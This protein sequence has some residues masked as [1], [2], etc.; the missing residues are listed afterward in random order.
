MN[1]ERL[2]AF[3]EER[4]SKGAL[5][6]VSNREPYIHKKTGLSIKIERPAGGL[7]SAIDDVLKATGG[8][9]VAW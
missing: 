7:V 4:F 3:I 1:S 9:W 2:K 5:I 6:V 8:I